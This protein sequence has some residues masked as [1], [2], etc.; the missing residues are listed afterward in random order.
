MQFGESKKIKIKSKRAY[1]LYLF[2]DKKLDKEVKT[3]CKIEVTCVNF[4]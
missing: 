4:I 1:Y 2:L 3:W